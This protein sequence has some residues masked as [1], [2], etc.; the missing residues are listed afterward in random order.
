MCMNTVDTWQPWWILQVKPQFAFQTHDPVGV[1]AWW[2]G[3]LGTTFYTVEYC[4][5]S[6]FLSSLS[7]RLLS[8]SSC[9]FLCISFIAFMFC[10]LVRTQAIGKFLGFALWFSCFVPFVWEMLHLASQLLPHVQDNNQI[11]GPVHLLSQL[12]IVSH[13]LPYTR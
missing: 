1:T 10:S 11:L 13:L 6:L 3:A 12:L 7:Q 5:C 8:S 2:L 4:W 9:F